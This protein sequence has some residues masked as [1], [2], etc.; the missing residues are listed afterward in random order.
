V[1]AAEMGTTSETLSRTLGKFR[2]HGLVRV[3]GKKITVTHPAKL[4]EL[5]RR[6]LGEL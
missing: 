4:A 1:L 3:S 2:D 5:L 6:H